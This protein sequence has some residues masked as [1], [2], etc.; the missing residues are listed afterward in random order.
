M[1]D[2]SFSSEDAVGGSRSPPARRYGVPKY[3]YLCAVDDE[4]IFLNLRQDTY[5]ALSGRPARAVAQVVKDWPVPIEID[6]PISPDEAWTV[7]D[8]LVEEGLLTFEIE[9]SKTGAPVQAIHD[10][11]LVSV[12][13]VIDYT[14][15][16]QLVDIAR[17]ISAYVCTA[18]SL[19]QWSLEDIVNRVRERKQLASEVLGDPSPADMARL[20]AVFRR[21]RVFTFS[22]RGQ[23]LF[24]ALLLVN[25]LA[26][27]RLFP[28]WIIGVQFTPFAA[29]SWVQHE[30]YIIDATPE[31]V[32]PYVPIFSV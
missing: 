6:S 10:C 18:Y 5:S 32:G 12:D 23:C 29:H 27:Y 17:F 8:H 22:A 9:D 1:L 25:F 28:A 2:A 16:I 3:V 21:L 14:T 11:S 19:R 24:H 26:R 7:A 15:H 20:I 13:Q 31:D 30:N 4:V